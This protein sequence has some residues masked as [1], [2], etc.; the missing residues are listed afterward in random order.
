LIHFFLFDSL[1]K[2]SLVTRSCKLLQTNHRELW[3]SF[4]AFAGRELTTM[5]SKTIYSA[6]NSS[7]LKNLIPLR[8]FI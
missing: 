7:N 3:A 1:G 4:A 8:A 6:G 2:Q 5:S